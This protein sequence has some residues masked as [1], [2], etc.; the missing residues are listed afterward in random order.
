M[1]VNEKSVGQ[2]IKNYKLIIEKNN[3]ET[4][5]DEPISFM[6]TK[7]CL[8]FWLKFNFHFCCL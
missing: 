5:L 1:Y 7:F 6:T 4:K 8:F 3:I 2:S